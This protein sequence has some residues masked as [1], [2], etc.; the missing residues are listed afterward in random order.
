[1][2]LMNMLSGYYSITR[3]ILIKMTI[4]IAQIKKGLFY[5][6]V[7]FETLKV[8]LKMGS[9]TIQEANKQLTENK[10]IKIE[11]HKLENT[12]AYNE[13]DELIFD[14]YNNH[15]IVNEKLF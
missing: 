14:R 6:H 4:K 15:Y 2:L 1:M 5:C 13:K 9:T 7:G 8:K 10:L 3:V 11:K 12:G